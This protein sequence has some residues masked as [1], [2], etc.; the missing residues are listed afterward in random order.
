MLARFVPIVRTFT[1]IIA[2]VSN[3][4]YRKFVTF[5]V[6]GGFIWAVG[7]TSLGYVL[8]KRFPGIADNLLYVSIIIIAISVLPMVVE[9]V[10]HRRD[11][12]QTV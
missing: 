9:L 5:N 7:V 10:K 12:R 2:G 11:Q 3:M 1:P 4:Q 8:G 6:V